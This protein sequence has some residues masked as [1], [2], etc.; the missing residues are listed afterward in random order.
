MHELV[1]FYLGKATLGS[2]TVPKEV[3]LSND[4]VN[5]NLRDSLRNPQSHALFIASRLAHAPIDVSSSRE[6]CLSA[7]YDTYL[8][9]S[10]VG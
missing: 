9:V 5:L 2:R 8:T 1:H 6:K 7:Y 10:V 3:C 4:C